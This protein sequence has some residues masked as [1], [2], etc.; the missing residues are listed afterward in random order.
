LKRVSLLLLFAISTLQAADRWERIGT[1]DFEIYSNAGETAARK[2]LN[3]LEQVRG[4]FLKA[5]PLPL[6][7]IFPV[8]IVVFKTLDQFRQFAQSES[9]RAFFAGGAQRDYIVMADSPNDYAYAIHEYMHLIVRHSGLHLPTWLNEGWSEV[10]STLR[11]VADG[12]AVGDLIEGRMKTLASGE[13]LDLATLTSVTPQSPIYKGSGVDIFYAESWALAHMLF[14]APDYSENF[15]KFLV[16]IHRGKTF[17][18]ACSIAYQ[19]TSAQVYADLRGYFDRKKMYGRVFQAP[20]AKSTGPKETAKLSEFDERLLLTDLLAV[21]NRRAEARAEYDRLAAQFPDRYE[22]AESLGYL[23]LSSGDHDA[24]RQNFTRAFGAGDADPRMCLRL[25]LLDREAKQPL[26]RVANELERAVNSSPNYVDALL[27]LGVV[28]IAQRDYEKGIAALMKIDQIQPE[29]APAVFSALSYAYFE[30]GDLDRAR[31]TAETARRYAR[32]SSETARLDSR[33]EMIDARARS[34]FPPRPGEKTERV[35][36]V[37]R[38]IVCKPTGNLMAAEVAGKVMTFDLP[39]PKAVEFIH[40]AG[41][42]LRVAC[43]PQRPVRLTIE[44]V[45]ASVMRLQTA[46][47]VRRIEY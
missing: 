28:R 24:A 10:Y 35:E 27:Q 4:F 17:D 41:P 45:P 47:V 38:E 40:E 15:P 34:P 36:G 22:V 42:A 13:W 21:A 29:Q 18:E 26:T 9:Q 20:L 37:L 16:A 44:Y 6:L 5:S 2:A 8:R 33:V 39:E 11:P 46:G 14:L 1:P 43:G 32:T 30:Q 7:D 3:H 25:A 19:K 31:K 23:A 12:V